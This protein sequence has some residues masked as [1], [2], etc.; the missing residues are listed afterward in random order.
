M[1]LLLLFLWFA[2]FSRSGD[3]TYGRLQA[4]CLQNGET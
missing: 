4:F 3:A 2:A 1:T